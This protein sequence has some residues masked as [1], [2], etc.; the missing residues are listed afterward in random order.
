MKFLA[1]LLSPNKTVLPIHPYKTSMKNVVKKHK[2]N[3]SF[4]VIYSKIYFIIIRKFCHA[5]KTW[6]IKALSFDE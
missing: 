3:V 6:V 4:V 1:L 5:N 2:Q